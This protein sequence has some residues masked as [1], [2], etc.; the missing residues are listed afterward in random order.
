M[1]EKFK[2]V[3]DGK[4]TIGARGLG[5]YSLADTMECGQCFRYEKI[6]REFTKESQGNNITMIEAILGEDNSYGIDVD[7]YENL[8]VWVSKGHNY[9]SNGGFVNIAIN[10]TGKTN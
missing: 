6:E 2:T 4:E 7:K 10:R 5:R 3:Y 8:G 1:F 9:Y